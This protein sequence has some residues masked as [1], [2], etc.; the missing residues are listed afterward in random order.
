M[1]SWLEDSVKMGAVESGEYASPG[2]APTEVMGV[3]R[4]PHPGVW[5][6]IIGENPRQ[7]RNEPEAQHHPLP[8]RPTRRGAGRRGMT[9]A[10]VMIAAVLLGFVVM[11]SL[12][13]LSQ[14]YGFTWQARMI[15]LAGQIVQ[16][17]MRI[18][19]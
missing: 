9:M 18:S 14:A 2:W 11:T 19:G 6:A 7:V 3:I 5:R 17:V 4:I 8:V 13:A 16:S 1:R 15:T 12:T 10:E